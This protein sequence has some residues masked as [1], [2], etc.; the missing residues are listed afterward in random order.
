MK[1]TDLLKPGHARSNQ[2]T[3]LAREINEREEV[4]ALT[5]GKACD[6]TNSWMCEV[7]L[8]GQAL[9]KVKAMLNHGDFMPWIQSHCP[10]ISDRTARDYMRVASNWQNSA[11]VQQATSI[12]MALRL[13]A[14]NEA[15]ANGHPKP[16]PKHWPPYIEALGRCG[17]L[18]AYIERNPLSGWPPEGRVKL[19]D[20]LA[21]VASVLWPEKFA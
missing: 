5:K 18:M 9:L 14:E 4:I 10:L 2:L 1:K 12:A 17:K 15:A 11:N 6:A 3:A 20:E 7:A 13:C 21:P 8:Q 16:E 19:R